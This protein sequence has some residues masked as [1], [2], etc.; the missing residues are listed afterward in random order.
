MKYLF[1]DVCPVVNIPFLSDES[2]DYPGI[3]RIVDHVIHSGCKSI[4]LFAFNSEPHKMTLEEKKA[5]IRHFLKAVDHRIETVVGLIDNSIRGVTE[6]G[7]KAKEYGADGI[8]LYPPSISCPA[9]E[10]LIR[11]FETVANAVQLPVMIQDNPRSTGVNMTT[12]F[13]LEIHRRIPAFRYLKVECAFPT[14]KIR[15][16]TEATNGGI[17]CYSGNGGIF[18]IDAHN[19]GAWGIM[20]GVA[21]CGKFVE[22]Y[23]HLHA[24]RENEARSIFEKLLPLVWFEDQS[25]EF[26]IAC[27][28]LLLH[29]LGIADNHVVRRPGAFLNAA[30]EKELVTLYNRVCPEAKV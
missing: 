1:Q 23:D 13:I 15:Q 10:E 12:E 28:K 19:C 17:K 26:Y 7:M 3:D 18:T 29:K 9:G 30:E 8:I 6:L 22:I 24:G 14:R 25:L 21:I 11:Y 4:C 27:E 20:P 5:V 2:I 16:I